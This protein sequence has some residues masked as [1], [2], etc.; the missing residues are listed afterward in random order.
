[1]SRVVAKTVDYYRRKARRARKHAALTNDPRLGTV[2]L[3]IAHQF[4]YLAMV[5]VRDGQS[6]AAPKSESSAKSARGRAQRG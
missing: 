4:E 2:W 1:M 6:P 3:A 5:I